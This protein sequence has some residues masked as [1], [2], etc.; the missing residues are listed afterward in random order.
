M[1][2][3]GVCKKCLNTSFANLENQ[4]RDSA[5]SIVDDAD[6]NA[7]DVS[8]PP[9][10]VPLH[11][12]TRAGKRGHYVSCG[13]VVIENDPAVSQQL[14]FT[15][16]T[17]HGGDGEHAAA[18]GPMQQ[19]ATRELANLKRKYPVVFSEPSYPVDRSGSTVF[20]HSIP[21]KDE[22]APAPKRRLYPLD[23]VELTELKV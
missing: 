10:I 2:L 19:L 8:K 4:L 7:N 13:M 9:E 20:E 16:R 3:G 14:H 1:S 21:L 18:H 11:Q 6:V 12:F 17:A 22:N 5:G 15:H 23:Q